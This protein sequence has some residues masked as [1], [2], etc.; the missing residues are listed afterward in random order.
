MKKNLLVAALLLS[1]IGAFGQGAITFNNRNTTAGSGGAAPV[2]APIFG[3]D[4]ANPSQQ[5]QG[6]PS[7]SWNG[8][9]GPTPVPLGTQVYH[10][11]PLAGSGF[12][13]QLWAADSQAPD[14][15]MAAIA[16]TSFRTITT[17]T[18]QGFLLP[19]AASPVVPG[20]ASDAVSRAKFQLRVWDN[21]GG[22]I[23]SWQQVLDPANGGVAR[24]WS[25]V[26]T[27]PFQLGAGTTTP[28]NLIGL[29][30]FQLFTVVPEPSVIALGALG[31]GCLLLLRRRK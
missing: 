22:T 3:V 26:F 27:V 30:S 21:K 20:V 28:P 1:A 31:A 12:T 24:G 14:S 25:T 19:L 18:F 15:A 10:G 6:N 29:E 11:T 4:P 2:V 23:S 9:S 8:T 17:V 5:L 16:T 7:A 13:A